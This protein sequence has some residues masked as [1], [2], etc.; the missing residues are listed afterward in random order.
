M[1][2]QRGGVGRERAVAPKIGKMH[3]VARGKPEGRRETRHIFCAV[4]QKVATKHPG[5][6]VAQLA[7]QMLQPLHIVLVRVCRGP[8]SRGS[9]GG[10]MGGPRVTRGAKVG[11]CC[12]CCQLLLVEFLCSIHHSLYSPLAPEIFKFIRNIPT[13]IYYEFSVKQR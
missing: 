7:G 11:P 4:S 12:V 10:A 13:M 1:S 6:V 2:R 5:I 3:R 8:R 9:E